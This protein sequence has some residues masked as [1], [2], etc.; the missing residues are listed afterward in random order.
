MHSSMV[1]ACD[2]LKVRH[3][4]CFAHTHNLVVQDALKLDNIQVIKK[5]KDIV[6]FFKC[7]NVTTQKFLDEQIHKSN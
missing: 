1:N 3:Y 5:C 7:S 4:P 2:I 6:T